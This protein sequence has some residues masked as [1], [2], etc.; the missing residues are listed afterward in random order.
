[1]IKIDRVCDS[2]KMLF[3]SAASG[4]RGFSV[5]A[6]DLGEVHLAVDHYHA[7]PGSKK[8]LALAMKKCPLCRLDEKEGRMEKR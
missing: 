1:M 4:M 3:S 8:H 6:E 5:I 7:T 2:Y